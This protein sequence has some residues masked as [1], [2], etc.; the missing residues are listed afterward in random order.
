M[1]TRFSIPA[2]CWTFPCPWGHYGFDYESEAEAEA[3][4]LAHV[5]TERAA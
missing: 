2:G 5:C 1:T 3:A 4:E